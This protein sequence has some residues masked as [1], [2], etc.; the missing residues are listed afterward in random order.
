ML[1]EDYE[2]SSI[3]RPFK[4]IRLP[5]IR[6]LVIDAYAHYLMRSCTNVERLI[7]HQRGFDT[8][9]LRSIPF[10]ANS[11]VYLALCL[12]APEIIQGVEVF[13]AYRLMS[14]SRLSQRLDLVRLCPD[15]EELAIVQVSRPDIRNTIPAH[16]TSKQ[17]YSFQ[18]THCITVAQGFKKLRLLEVILSC[19]LEFYSS[20][21]RPIGESRMKEHA[22]TVLDN[23]HGH[24]K[25]LKIIS[26][27]NF[28]RWEDI[29][30]IE[31]QIITVP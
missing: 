30:D 22:V 14:D 24:T 19:R 6:T 8:T 25:V 15:L 17:P 16:L 18:L 28:S 10:V 13:Y 31:T 9:Y 20:N 27:D 29:R 11:L 12:P 4:S 23:I 5:Q 21:L 2:E 26:M 7:I 1:T 3:K